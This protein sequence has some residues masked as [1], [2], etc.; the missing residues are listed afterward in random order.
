ME[1]SKDILFEIIFKIDD[2]TTYYNCYLVNRL[3]NSICNR[4]TDIKKEE[5]KREIIGTN[6]KYNIL[7]NGWKHGLYQEWYGN[8]ILMIKCNYNNNNKEGL[9]QI[10]YYNG[11]LLSECYYKNNKREGIYYKYYPN[12]QLKFKCNYKND[13]LIN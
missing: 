1:L 13:L 2:S 7:P 9:Y 11:E 10:F 6:Y 8:D 5:F 12:G 3:F 4:L